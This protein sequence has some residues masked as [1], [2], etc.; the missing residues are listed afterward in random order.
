[1]KK[2]LKIVI[3][4]LAVLILLV[5]GYVFFFHLRVDI[6]TGLMQDLAE[7]QS[8]SGHYGM[9]IR[10]YQWARDLDPQNGELAV[11]MAEVYRKSGNYTKTESTLV[12]AIYD[13]PA[14]ARLYAALS[15]VYVEQDK[16][17]DAQQLL[18]NISN[19][20][21]KAELQLRRPEPPKVNPAGGFYND[22]ITVEIGG[23]DAGTVCCTVDGTYPSVI[24]D[25][26]EGPIRLPA[27][28]TT[29]CALTVSSEGLVSPAVYT[30]YTVAG[31]V[32]DVS[33]HDEALKA[34]TQ[35]L[36]H[37]G[38]RT[39]RTD[40]LWS[41]E[42]FTLPEGLQD[43]TD[44][45]L[46]T[47]MNKLT[48]RGLGELDYSFLSAMTELRYLDLEGCVITVEALRQ[49][50]ACE[51]LEVLILAD[52]GLSN[53]E[54]LR[55]LSTLRVLDLSNNSISSI[56]AI[57][58]LRAL[59]ELYL[60]HNA[61]TTVPILRDMNTLRILDLSYNAIE[62]AGGL[63][64]CPT[65]ER[66]NLSHNRL[67]TVTPLSALVNLV[68][69]DVSNNAVSDTAPLTPCTKLESFFMSE[70]KLTEV[71]FLGGCPK[72]LEVNIDY[73]DV[74]RLPVF[75]PDCPLQSISAAHNYLESLN[76]LGGLQA[77]AYVNAD[78]NN[79]RDISILNGCPALT[80]V[81]VYGTYVRSGGDLAK[82]GV[83]VNFTPGF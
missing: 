12:H 34:A 13:A 59:D 21:A 23:A 18:D 8:E 57:S 50:A 61:L 32:E 83:I 36:L 7:S 27:G 58:A 81:N 74:V 19:P 14:D 82:N 4:I 69:L 60:G 37:R 44:L 64:A 31:V 46:Y 68:W 41:I 54:P 30:G 24:D 77:L 11:R 33:F 38:D 10:C 29:I 22:Y 76:G 35:E 78:Y 51:H 56:S 5:G 9:A 2:S 6:T 65:I 28:T 71:D 1:M 63:S 26:Y 73:N 40:D 48:G 3:P 16:L 62:N 17:L 49:I 67:K 70:N 75:Q 25:V 43:T 66:L 15:R 80:Q 45:R 47:H 55:R 39:L 20:D 53:L 42:S 79:I 72:L 52:C